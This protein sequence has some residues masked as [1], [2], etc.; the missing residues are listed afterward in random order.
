MVL[1]KEERDEKKHFEQRRC[2]CNLTDN[3]V[4]FK[5]S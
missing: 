1:G 2:W 3:T 5:T 4:N